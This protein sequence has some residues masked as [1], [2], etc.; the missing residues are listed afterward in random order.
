MYIKN[1]EKFQWNVLKHIKYYI[2][3]T[4]FPETRCFSRDF[5]GTVIIIISFKLMACVVHVYFRLIKK[6]SLIC[7]RPSYF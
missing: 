6:I 3:T 5:I 2:I 4:I 7:L 1:V